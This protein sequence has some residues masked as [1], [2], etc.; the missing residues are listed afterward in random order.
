MYIYSRIFKKGNN[1][2][3]TAHN[4]GNNPITVT[5]SDSYTLQVPANSMA[6]SRD[7]NVEGLS[8][9]ESIDEVLMM[10]DLTDTLLADEIALED[11]ASEIGVK[12]ELCTEY[13]VNAPN[14]NLE[15]CRVFLDP[16]FDQFD[17]VLMLDIDTLV[18]TRENI[19]NQ[20]KVFGSSLIDIFIV[21]ILTLSIFLL[22]SKLGYLIFAILNFSD[23]V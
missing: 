6:T 12:Y 13:V 8:E 17:K 15:A 3:Y 18:N 22:E 21:L 2:T 19:F 10:V 11:I 9:D 7:I 1:K 5:F 20:K 23:G 4:Y 14:Q 16:H